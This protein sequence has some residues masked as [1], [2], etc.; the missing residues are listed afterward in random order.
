MAFAALG[1]AEVLTRYPDHAQARRL[2]ADAAG[3]VTVPPG[4]WPWPEARLRYANASLP[5][6]LL[7]AGHLL[8]D[9]PTLRA[10]LAMLEW[11]LSVETAGDHLSVT[12][13]GGWSAG[14]P[15]PAF[16]QQPIE[17]ATLAEACGRA[18]EITGAEH[19]QQ[20]LRRCEAWFR[21]ANDTG[22]S[23]VDELTGGGYDGLERRGRN[24]NQ[25]AESTMAVISTFQITRRLKTVATT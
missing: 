9:P 6:T 21:G 15:R 2:L 20:A 24:E 16:D 3:R 14:E 19:F 17:V 13:V 11:L 25:G 4:R 7:A 23:L 5:E 12:P 10:G 8:A 1:A 22:I 18:Y